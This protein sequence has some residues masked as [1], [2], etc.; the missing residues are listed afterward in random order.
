MPDET[1]ILVDRYVLADLVRD[2]A[3]R[4]RSPASYAVYLYL[5][6]RS[7][8]GSD[9]VRASHQSISDETGLAKRTVQ[10]ALR[11]LHRRGLVSSVRESMTAVPEYTIHRP[12]LRRQRSKA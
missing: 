8:G 4:D 12:W 11:R 10:E 3:G 1:E 5:W 9:A 2:L 7:S 6:G